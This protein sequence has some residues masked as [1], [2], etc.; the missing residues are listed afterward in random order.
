MRHQAYLE[1]ITRG[2]I[3][4]RSARLIRDELA[5]HLEHCEDELIAQGWSPTAA[6][7][8]SQ[9]RMGDPSMQAK[10]WRQFYYASWLN[11]ETLIGFAIG[12]M[13]GSEPWWMGGGG[14]PITWQADII[15][16]GA[17]A[18]SLIA[19]LG[20][21]GQWRRCAWSASR[22]AAWSLVRAFWIA[23]LGL[24]S[25]IG[26]GHP[27]PPAGITDWYNWGYVGHLGIAG[28]LLTGMAMIVMWASARQLTRH[29]AERRRR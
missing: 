18:L 4:P 10:A 24:S 13:V 2:I 26:L 21:V 16:A 29:T 5:S 7:A 9:R 1:R 11:R 28:G 19:V 12:V 17:I 22:F 14:S 3:G 8:E 27:M 15:E 20:I 6:A 25:I 23:S